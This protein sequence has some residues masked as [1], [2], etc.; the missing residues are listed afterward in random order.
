MMMTMMM[1]RRT[2]TTAIIVL[3]AIPMI[4]E[5]EPVAT[6]LTRIAVP[7]FAVLSITIVTAMGVVPTEADQMT[8]MMTTLITTPI[9]IGRRSRGILL[10]QNRYTV[11]TVSISLT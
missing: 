4:A 3:R 9:F 7:A 2:T 5:T 6:A 11:T 1:G 8:T 10:T